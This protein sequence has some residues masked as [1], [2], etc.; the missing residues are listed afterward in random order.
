MKKI[1]FLLVLLGIFLFDS[2][3]LAQ[4]IES[5]K[6]IVNG[7]NPISSMTK[8]QIS[9]LF[10]KKVTKWKNGQK[11]LPLDLTGTSP[12]RQDFSKEILGRNV[13]AIKAY[14]QKQIFSGRGV[15]P[16]EKSSDREVLAYVQEN[17][18]A[19]GY[20]SASVI[21]IKYRVKVLNVEK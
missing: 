15:P 10:L 11:V 2:V 6:I 20:I 7:S 16:P 13:W 4:E 9:K 21:T 8:D 1:I 3:S 17:P 18:G 12:V 5:Y 14:W 19:I